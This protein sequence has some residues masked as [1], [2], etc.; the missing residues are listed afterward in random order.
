MFAEIYFQNAKLGAYCEARIHSVDP[1]FRVKLRFPDGRTV[2]TTSKN[3]QGHL[4]IGA[5]VTFQ[6][7]QATVVRLKDVS[8]YVVIFDDFDE[9][10]IKRGSLCIKGQRHFD[11]SVTLDSLP[12]NDP[13]HFGDKVTNKD[14]L[15][16]STSSFVDDDA[17]F[18]TDDTSVVEE[19]E[20]SDKKDDAISEI[21]ADSTSEKNDPPIAPPVE[22]KVT[23]SESSVLKRSY[24]E[25]K[26]LPDFETE[27]AVNQGELDQADGPEERI[28]I[29]EIHLFYLSNQYQTLKGEMTEIEKILQSQS[30][31]KDGRKK[32]NRLN[33]KTQSTSSNSVPTD[34][35]LS[36]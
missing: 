31:K 19:P 30:D 10:T 17:I 36:N 2:Q 29:L 15:N 8:N 26:E 20:I 5:Q 11:D 22:S 32:R 12:L 25:M 13:E 6:G 27:Y 16:Q 28:N 14:L 3:C 4:A 9:R 7:L 33:S 18:T 23:I 1:E 34:D 24:L 21:S 35:I